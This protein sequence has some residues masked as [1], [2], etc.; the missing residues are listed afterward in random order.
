MAGSDPLTP[1][2]PEAERSPIE[3]AET[4]GRTEDAGTTAKATAQASYLGLMWWRFKRNRL[5]VLGSLALLVI[6]AVVLPAEFVAPYALNQRHE[7]YLGV[8]PQPPRFITPDGRFTLRPIM[9]GL[10][11]ERDPVTLRRRFIP[12]PEQRYPIRLLVRGAPWT[13]LG[14]ESDIHLF[15]VEGQ[16]RMLLLG[17]DLQGRDMLSQILY[18]GRIS[19]T[20]GMVGVAISMLLGTLIGLASGYIGGRFDDFVQ[21]TV[22]VLVSFPSIPL[23]IALSAAIPPEWSSIR[24]FFAITV[25]LSLIG[26]GS[27]ARVVRGMTLSLKNEDFVQASRMNGGTTW[28][29]ITRHMFPGM[30]SYIIVRVT[31]AIPG[32]ILGETALSFLGLGIQPPMVSWGVLLQQVQNISA[33]AHQPWLMAPVLFLVI[34]V[35][36]F[37]FTGD[38]LRDAADPFSSR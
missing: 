27:L 32:M 1:L 2:P 31:L 15:G 28:W 18:G 13:L 23:W 29:I 25:I 34:T 4:E 12:D 20:V 9:L 36:A 33:L 22:E 30:L 16:G 3:M 26:W 8:P 10:K 7:A 17:T 24:V 14:I 11:P 19:L 5:G 38:G 6:Y 35:L 37:N 21:R